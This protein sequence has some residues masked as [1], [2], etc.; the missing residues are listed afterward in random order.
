MKGL[1][2]IEALALD[3]STAA[4]E[5][6]HNRS[7]KPDPFFREELPAKLRRM[8]LGTAYALRPK[9]LPILPSVLLL[10]SEFLVSRKLAGRRLGQKRYRGAEGL[11]GISEDLSPQAILDNYRRGMFPFAHLGPMAW[12]SPEQRA[13]LRPDEGHIEKSLRRTIRKGEYRVTFDTDFAAVMRAC[14]ELRPGKTPLTWV[15]PKIMRAFFAL[16][17][18]G[19]AHS[20]EVWDAQDQLVGGLYGVA[21]GGVYFGESQFSRVRDASKIANVFLNRHLAHWGFAVR[22]AKWLSEHLAG[23]GFRNIERAEFERILDE[24][25][26]KPGRTGRWMVD[27]T[28]DVAGWQPKA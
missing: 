18:Q 16:H 3:N 26:W 4:A 14:A 21:I 22:D 23:L 6:S 1:A 25:A 11:A 12:W 28:L 20:V 2:P 8:V 13:V 19:H 7:A 5:A 9:R 27:E 15:T 10:K 17:Q 24:H